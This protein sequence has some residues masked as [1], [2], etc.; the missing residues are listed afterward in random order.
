VP[1]AAAPQRPTSPTHLLPFN[2]GATHHDVHHE[3]VK[4]NYAG[5]LQLW[6][7]VFG[8]FARGYGEELAARHAA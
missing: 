4:G 5:F 7:R 1:C 6:D 8:T 2:D 3:R